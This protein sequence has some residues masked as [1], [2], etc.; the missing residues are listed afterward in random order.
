VKYITSIIVA[1]ALAFALPAFAAKGD[2]NSGNG[3]GNTGVGNQGNSKPVGNAGG[4]SS[5]ETP[6]T[7]GATAAGDDNPAYGRAKR[8]Y[9]PFIST[10]LI[11]L[12]FVCE[13]ENG[14]EDK[15]ELVSY[16]CTEGEM[17]DAFESYAP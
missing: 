13:K 9:T 2:G 17:P 10:A 14:R 1:L 11:L 3:V 12:G 7:P 8:D 5:S 16:F 15:T 4:S 6:S